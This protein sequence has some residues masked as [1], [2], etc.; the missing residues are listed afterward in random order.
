MNGEFKFNDADFITAMKLKKAVIG[1]VKESNVDLSKIDMDNL[2]LASIDTI[3]QIILAAD[4]SE[5]VEKA[6]F[7]CLKRC[8]Y[9]GE[10]ITPDTF[11]PIEARK[12]YYDI[13]IECLKGNLG[14]FFEPLYL[15]L[16]KLFQV[17]PETA[18]Q[19]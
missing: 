12:D 8:T 9:N 4:S 7:D 1:A 15:K 16:Q 2:N 14:P 18:D 3:G 17:Q 10:K 5:K 13:I 11:E 19:K 6:I